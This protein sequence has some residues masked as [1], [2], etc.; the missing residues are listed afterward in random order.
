MLSRLG[1]LP[2]IEDAQFQP[3][4]GNVVWWGPSETEKRLELF[5]AGVS[6]YQVRRDRL[7]R[8]LQRLARESGAE[9]VSGLVRKVDLSPPGVT[10]QRDDRQ[11]TIRAL[12]VL[13]CTGRAGVVA[14]KRH[15]RPAA[16]HTIALAATWRAPDGWR[17]LDNAHTSVASYGD[18]WAWSIAAEPGA[19]DFTVMIDPSRTELQRGAGAREVYLAEIEK[20]HAFRDLLGT[21]TMMAGPWGAD[22]SS[23][24]AD[25]YAGDGFLLV[26]DA[27]SSIDPLSSFGVKKAL[28]SGW[29][30]AVSVHTAITTPAMAGHAWQFF[31]RRER[32]M[33]ASAARQSAALA[34]LANGSGDHPFW[35]ARAIAAD[36]PDPSA[37]A[38]VAS[39]ARDPDV[40]RAFDDLRRRDST[41]F[42]AGPNLRIEPR[43]A[44]RDRHIV[45]DDHLILR[46]WPDGIRYLRN[47]D[48]IVLVNL[49]PAHDDIGTLCEAVLRVQ[50][51]V[52]LPDILGGLSVLIA[53]GAL[54]TPRV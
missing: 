3:W 41:R 35:L 21:A 22:A 44:V 40:L 31:E 39:L 6:G 5:P 12:Y 45:F 28:V 15:R 23:Y 54:M 37:T 32:E 7:D 13:D 29:L 2:A 9:F 19:R 33:V 43:P 49:A 11:T 30:A 34:G 1:A 27:A 18:G 42:V 20:V 26:G 51:G 53:R 17:D 24:D 52:A 50:P 10:L 48:L 47:V 4:R 38:D 25:R 8:C 14:R 36:D 16:L 46:D